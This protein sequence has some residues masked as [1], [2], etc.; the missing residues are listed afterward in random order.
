M[1]NNDHARLSPG[2]R[3]IK[4]ALI[5]FVPKSNTFL[6]KQCNTC[7][8]FSTFIIVSCS[9]RFF[10]YVYLL[11]KNKTSVLFRSLTDLSIV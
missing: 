9:G 3:V 7:A 10:E 4:G 8:N 11:T 1:E 5:F 6:G 2:I